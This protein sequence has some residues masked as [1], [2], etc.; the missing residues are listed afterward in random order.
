V[1][2]VLVAVVSWN[3]RDLLARCLSSMAGDARLEVHV[4]DNASSDGSADMVRERFPGVRLHA[5]E[6]N[7]GYGRAVN[8]A[9]AA[10]SPA[11][12]VAAVN[13]DTALQ[14]GALDALLAAGAADPGAGAIA[15]RLILP[16]GSTQHSAHPFPTLP[17][18]VAF[19]L[20]LRRAAWP[21]EGRWDAGRAARVPWALGA[22]LLVRRP[23]WEAV[24]GFDAS[25]W[26]YAEDL[27]LGWRLDR[28]GWAT[29]YEPSARVLHES[30]ASTSQAFGDRVVEAWQAATYDWMRRRR[31]PGRA[32][33]VAA[34]NVAG[35]AARW[36]WATARRRP[37]Q[38]RQVW[39]RWA[40]THASGLR[41]SPP[42]APPGRAHP[43]GD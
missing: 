9:V 27:D 19:N 26:M 1:A 40:R 28:A 29:R 16:D 42:A 10:G 43:R 20:G 22:F 31:G 25:R 14:P 15:P 34:V 35:A 7:A 3:T 8:L 4:V 11:P 2:E 12:W 38:E 33:A 37:A 39:A 32:A 30:A 6:D 5:L 17:F 36:G 41:S 21:L 24:G 18:T 13:A 23:A